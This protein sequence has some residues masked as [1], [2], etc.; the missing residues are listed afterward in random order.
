MCPQRH[1][2]RAL[3]VGLGLIGSSV[4]LGLRESGW[5]VTGRDASREREERA[6]ALGV[7]D[8]TGEDVDASLAV[9]ATPVGTIASVVLSIF[10]GSRNAELVVT[11]VGSVKASV[12]VA[13]D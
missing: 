13:V 4:A 8:V 12:V 6:L 5:H 2:R 1:P 10:E 9:V 7:V 3:V 11:D